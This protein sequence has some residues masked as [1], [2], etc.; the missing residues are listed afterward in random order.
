MPAFMMEIEQAQRSPLEQLA[1]DYFTLRSGL[2]SLDFC[3]RAVGVREDDATVARR[4]RVAI[5]TVRKWR[6]IGRRWSCS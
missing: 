5:S 3:R 2:P 1:V 4:L 6:E